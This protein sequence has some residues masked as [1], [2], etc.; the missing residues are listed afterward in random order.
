MVLP[1]REKV[2]SSLW[3]SFNA[4]ERFLVLERQIGF[5][6]P[7]EDAA[8]FVKG[9]V[10]EYVVQ[11][12]EPLLL[13]R[14]GEVPAG[15]T[16]ESVDS[17]WSVSDYKVEAVIQI[18]LF[19]ESLFGD[20]VLA[21]LSLELV[22]LPQR[23]LSQDVLESFSDE[24]N[25]LL[26]LSIFSVSIDAESMKEISH[27]SLSGI[28]VKTVNRSVQLFGRKSTL[29]SLIQSQVSQYLIPNSVAKVVDSKKERL[30][31]H[32]KPSKSM[33]RYRLGVQCIVGDKVEYNGHVFTIKGAN[34]GANKDDPQVS[35][36]ESSS[37]PRLSS[38]TFIRRARRKEMQLSEKLM[39]KRK[40]QFSAQ[41]SG[42]EVSRKP[43]L[44]R[45]TLSMIAELDVLC[46]DSVSMGSSR[47]NVDSRSV[48]VVDG[49]SWEE[50]GRVDILASFSVYDVFSRLQTDYK[51]VC[52]V[53][54]IGNELFRL[55]EDADS[56]SKKLADLCE[57][58]EYF[59][60][61]VRDGT[62]PENSLLA[63]GFCNNWVLKG[64]RASCAE[65]TK[66]KIRHVLLI[67]DY[68]CKSDEVLRFLDRTSWRKEGNWI[69]GTF[70][71][72][73]AWA[74]DSSK[75]RRET[76]LEQWRSLACSLVGDVRL[77]FCVPYG[78]RVDTTRLHDLVVDIDALF[79]MSSF[80]FFDIL[81]SGYPETAGFHSMSDF[82]SEVGSYGRSVVSI[83][84]SWLPKST[85]CRFWL[86]G[87]GETDVHQD[88][89]IKFFK[90]EL[91]KFFEAS[92]AP[93]GVCFERVN[94]RQIQK[95]DSGNIFP[96]YFNF[97]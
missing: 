87:A 80:G 6:H 20:H 26:N 79:M 89:A 71:D 63:S 84:E 7:V 44:S 96:L 54:Q 68:D 15:L 55:F 69:T 51:A 31:P 29:E 83:F 17:F 4:L 12:H 70:C 40:L 94:L 36:K 16:K 42:S 82:S 19:I 41:E 81:F 37:V 90:D 76:C 18:P 75:W 9:A 1:P 93:I 95:Q 24:L 11:N 8:V 33:Y 91:K 39:V 47:R 3:L 46:S 62:A 64:E 65:K 14:R 22:E 34:A 57:G 28:H 25:Q 10:T 61:L 86:V 56:K 23:S 97:D 35:L 52:V 49:A 13:L 59:L 2:A 92:R 60:I 38:V 53:L 77:M 66:S 88:W 50:V 78:N 5:T 67:G 58:Q 85:S 72:S 30:T 45:L 73:T 27:K 74:L 21:V 48:V 43:W 32:L